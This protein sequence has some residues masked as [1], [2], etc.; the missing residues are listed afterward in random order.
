MSAALGD[1]HH[2]ALELESSPAEVPSNRLRQTE[3]PVYSG[4]VLDL[5]VQKIADIARFTESIADQLP[6]SLEVD[7]A[8][9]FRK[10][11]L[12]DLVTAL[13]FGPVSKGPASDGKIEFFDH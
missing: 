1:M 10:M 11:H 7:V 12:R 9:S 13:S 6:A 5:L 4:Q 3:T 8:E 2:L